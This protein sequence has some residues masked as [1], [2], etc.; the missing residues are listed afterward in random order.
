MQLRHHFQYFGTNPDFLSEKKAFV[1][2]IYQY[3]LISSYRFSS[4]FNRI[5]QIS[6]GFIRTVRRVLLQ[7]QWSLFLANSD[8]RLPVIADYHEVNLFLGLLEFDSN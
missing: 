2:Y 4:P 6:G 5:R 8:L 7:N 3:A 1:A